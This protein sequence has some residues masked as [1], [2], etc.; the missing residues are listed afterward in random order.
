M[1]GKRLR[2]AARGY[3]TMSKSTLRKLAIIFRGSLAK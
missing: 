1:T 3:S 2:I